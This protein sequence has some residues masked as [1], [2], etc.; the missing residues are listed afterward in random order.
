MN[1][2]LPILAGGGGHKLIEKSNIKITEI[3]KYHFQMIQVSTWYACKFTNLFLHL[4]FHIQS[5][6]AD[7][8]IDSQ[9]PIKSSS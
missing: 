9:K 7:L 6:T 1:L 4:W 3:I 8:S 5:A 2:S